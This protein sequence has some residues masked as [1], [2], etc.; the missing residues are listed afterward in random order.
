[1]KEYFPKFIIT[2]PSF[3]HPAPLQSTITIS[4]SKYPLTFVLTTVHLSFM[5][6]GNDVVFVLFLIYFE[7]H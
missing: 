5:S 4:Y 3:N 2:I 7:P 6:T 1:M